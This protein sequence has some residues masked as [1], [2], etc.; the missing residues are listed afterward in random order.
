MT[1]IE[2]LEKIMLTEIELA[3]ALLGV[4]GEQ[5]EAI[6]C[7]EPDALIEAIGRG[8]ELVQPLESLERERIRISGELW[9][10][11]GDPGADGAGVTVSALTDRLADGDAARIG[12]LGGRLRRTVEKI[13]Q[14]N[15]ENK[16]LIDNALKFVRENMRIIREHFP[17][18]LVDHKM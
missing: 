17:A 4:L 11:I 2:D 8:E 10:E 18:P 3:E 15:T 1:T 7:V 14:I 16:P 12:G 6:V 9:R 5:R 13:L